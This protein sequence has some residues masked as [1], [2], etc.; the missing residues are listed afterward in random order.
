MTDAD[1]DGSHI[2]TLLL[3]FFYRQMPDL[4]EKG[5]LYIAQPPL[6]RVQK[7]K[8]ENY[9]KNEAALDEYL[10][11]IGTDKAK[12]IA[13]D[14]ELTGRDLKE[15]AQEAIA[16]RTLLVRV[17]RR[18]DSR[19]VD[20][21]IRLGDLDLALLKDHAAIRAQVEK[22]GERAQRLHPELEIRL[23]K[24]ERDV[25]HDCDMLVF[26]TTVAGAQRETR[27][28]HDYLS[29]AEWEELNALHGALAELGP[30]PFQIETPEGLEEVQDVFAA[31][32]ALKRASAQGQNIQRYKGLGEMNPEQLWETT[33]DPARRTMLQ[34][35]V[36]DAVEA[37]EVFS[38]LMGDA[39][40]P[41]REFIE[42]H[43]LDVQNLD[44]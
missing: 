29:G 13:G 43:A 11:T 4:I 6:Y 34:V 35:K 44:I 7:G 36:D 20:A 17:E 2:R 30:G 14:D 21:A 40:E 8:R 25:E 1:V 24:I 27:L 42:K 16:Y 38:I 32:E 23:A 18:R 19:I 31:V 33:M 5:Y 9:L 22:I 10:L 26:R 39:V 3:T 28:D 41:R 12:L 37:N 15:L